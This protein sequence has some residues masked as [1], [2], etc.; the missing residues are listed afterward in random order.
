MLFTRKVCEKLRKTK[1]RKIPMKRAK[2]KNMKNYENTSTFPVTCSRCHMTPT[3]SGFFVCMCVICVRNDE[4]SKSEAAAFRLAPSFL[5]RAINTLF[6]Y[7]LSPTALCFWAFLNHGYVS[8]NY[9]FKDVTTYTTCP[10]FPVFC[11]RYRYVVIES[12][13]NG[14]F[15]Y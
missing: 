5:M 7:P 13:H 4:E 9:V 1:H 3:L 10:I 2:R 15:F 11:A 8:L 14:G 12:P 6:G